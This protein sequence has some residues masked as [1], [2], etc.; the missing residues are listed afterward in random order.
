MVG[1][2]HKDG[3]VGDEAQAN[4]AI[5]SLSIASHHGIVNTWDDTVSISVRLNLR[6]F[7]LCSADY[8]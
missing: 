5:L 2:G 6:T 1:M 8:V 4:R 3:H 7:A